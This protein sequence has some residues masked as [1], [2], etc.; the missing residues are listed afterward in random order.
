MQP[1]KLYWMYALIRIHAAPRKFLKVLKF[2][3]FNLKVLYS[4]E[5]SFWFLKVLEIK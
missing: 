1:M 5:K 4:P 2:C 3:P